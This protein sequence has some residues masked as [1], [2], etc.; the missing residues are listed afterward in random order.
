MNNL[1]G[2]N[3]RNRRSL[4][5]IKANIPVSYYSTDAQS[6]EDMKITYGDTMFLSNINKLHL[7]PDPLKKNLADSVMGDTQVMRDLKPHNEFG[8]VE[9][10][11][12]PT[13]KKELTTLTSITNYFSGLMNV[14]GTIFQRRPPS[15][16]TQYY[17]CFDTESSREMAPFNW[18][19]S[20]LDV[21][22]KNERSFSSNNG[23]T[24]NMTISDCK[25]SAESCEDKLNQVRLL[26]SGTPKL[27]KSK[28][29][30]GEASSI[31]ESFEDAF[32][33][34]DIVSL[35]NDTFIEYYSAFNSHSDCLCEADAPYVKTEVIKDSLDTSTNLNDDKFNNNCSTSNKSSDCK[36]D[37]KYEVVSSC[38]DKLSKIK[39]LLQSKCKANS[40]THEK[41]EPISINNICDTSFADELN[42]NNSNE[43][44]SSEPDNSFDEVKGRFHSSSTDSND[45]FQIVFSDSRKRLPS[46]CESEDSFIVFDESPDSCYTSHDVFGNES[47]L[48]SDFEEDS[49]CIQTCK[50][51]HSL[52]RTFCD[53]T[54]N[55]L[56]SA[57]VP[58]SSPSG[59]DELDA[60]VLQKCSE[61]AL[62]SDDTKKQ[63]DKKTQKKVHVM[64]VWAFAARQA[65]I[66]DWETV[67][68]DRDRFKRRIADV[69]VAISWVLKPQHRSRVVFQRFMPWW[70]AQKRK[71][72]AEKKAQK[73]WDSEATITNNKEEQIDISPIEYDQVTENSDGDV[74]NIDESDVDNVEGERLLKYESEDNPYYEDDKEKKTEGRKTITSEFLTKG[75]CGE[76]KE[77]GAT[78]EKRDLLI[79]RDLHQN[80]HTNIYRLNHERIKESKAGA[81]EI[82]PFANEIK[83]EISTNSAVSS[84]FGDSLCEKSLVNPVDRQRDVSYS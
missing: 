3:S 40:N 8:K 33:P 45:S 37:L 14:M 61:S 78:V 19:P 20:K 7:I 63:E 53:L 4:F 81:K 18:Q 38:E 1:G 44:V 82:E 16:V 31:E 22:N 21:Q 58:D 34:E 39:A 30:V 49:G 60:V 73:E 2:L 68:R 48:E 84:D 56:Y 50:L 74:T 75:H 65:R 57:D 36:D 26:L 41:T 77:T 9:V 28:R 72:L 67:A 25:S 11:P 69:D 70:N 64:R 46:D 12:Q 83:N 24:T 55:S 66:G 5:D 43:T 23:S 32:C 80:A 59:S 52:S 71:E 47:D 54:D 13:Q 6:K 42:L 10:E 76:D 62:C 27:G 79:E 15:P 29:V 35:A 17:D 51:D